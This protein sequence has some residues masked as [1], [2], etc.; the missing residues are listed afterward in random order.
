MQG[1]MHPRKP[2]IVL[3]LEGRFK[4]QVGRKKHKVPLVPITRSGIQNQTWFIRLCKEY[5]YHDITFGPLLRATPEVQ[6]AAQV[7]HLDNWFHKYLLDLQAL[8]KDLILDTMDVIN[9][10]SVKRSL[11]W[12]STTQARNLCIPRDIM[13]LNNQWRFEDSKGFK[14]GAPGEMLEVYTDKLAAIESI[15]QYSEPL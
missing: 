3:A 1:L 15:L 2:H 11:R 14:T 10:Y 4:G 13:N 7:K 6:N 9:L 8:C 5:E 12:G